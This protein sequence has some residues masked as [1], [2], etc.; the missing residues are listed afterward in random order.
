MPR[1]L[2]ILAQLL[3]CAATLAPQ[4]KDDRPLIVAQIS[5]LHIGL[6]KN[7]KTGEPID[8]LA[9]LRRIIAQVNE[10]NPDVVIISGDIGETPQAWQQTRDALKAL[11]APVKFIPGN[12]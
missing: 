12:H 9:N 11:H 2:L 6:T 3:L 5:D 7:G 8:P 1:K 4:D 10:R